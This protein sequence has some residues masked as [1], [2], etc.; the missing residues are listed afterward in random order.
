MSYCDQLTGGS[1]N[2]AATFGKGF[3][4]GIEPDI[5][6]RMRNFVGALAMTNPSCVATVYKRW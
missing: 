3:A 1:A 2:I 5:P 6:E 4:Y